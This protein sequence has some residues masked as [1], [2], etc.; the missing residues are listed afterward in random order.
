MA[1]FRIRSEFQ[2]FILNPPVGVLLDVERSDIDQM[3]WFVNVE[4]AAN[5][6]YEGEKYVLRVRFNDD[7][8]FKAPEVVFVGDSIPCNPHVYSNGH[9]CIS[10]LGE[11]WSPTLD[12]QAVCLSIISMLSSCKKKEWPAGNETYVQNV[13]HVDYRYFDG[14]YSDTKC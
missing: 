9:I 7:Y 8:P 2:A 5:T 4:G 3:C 6:L 13:K 11:E 12:I 10:I 1:I 14:T